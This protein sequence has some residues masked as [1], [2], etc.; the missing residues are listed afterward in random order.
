M[1]GLVNR[2]LEELICRQHGSATWERIKAEAGVEE[3]VFV[4][5]DAYPD[6]ITYRLVACASQVLGVSPEQLLHDFGVHWTQYTGREGYKALLETA[7]RSLPEVLSNLDDLHVRVGLMYPQL[8][9]PSFRCTDQTSTSLVLHYH[10]A[11]EGL[12]PMVVGLVKGLGQHFGVEVSVT[13]RGQRANGEDH[14]SFEV[15]W[16]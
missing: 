16:H 1:Y 3:E 15:T 14:D 12:G 8:R 7:G 13:P 5:M 11:R 2:G 6:E 9:P 10:S 4:R